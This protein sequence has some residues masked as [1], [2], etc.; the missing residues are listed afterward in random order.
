[1]TTSLT[2]TI[3]HGQKE[4][5][6]NSIEEA[7]AFLCKR[8]STLNETDARAKNVLKVRVLDESFAGVVF[9]VSHGRKINEAWVAAEFAT[10]DYTP[11]MQIAQKAGYRRMWGSAYQTVVI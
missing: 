6:F 5:S 2:V 8:H 7:N 9:T 4:L 1:M 11:T 10:I 3:S